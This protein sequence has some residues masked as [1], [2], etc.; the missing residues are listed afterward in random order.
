MKNWKSLMMLLIGLLILGGFS[1][2][3]LAST[4]QNTLVVAIRADIINLDPAYLEDAPTSA[5]GFQIYEH[6]IRRDFDGT[7]APGLA[8]D[9]EINDVADEY[10]LFLREGVTFHDGSPF[11]AEV[12]KYHFARIGDPATGS[13]EGEKVRQSIKEVVVVDEYTVRFELFDSNA[14]FIEDVLIG[15]AMYIASPTAIEKYGEDFSRNPSGT[16]PFKFVSW[17]PDQEVVLERNMDY[18]AGAPNIERVVFRPIPEATTQITELR[19]GTV[20]IITSIPTEYIEPLD[21]DP[22]IVVLNEPDFNLRYLVFNYAVEVLQDVNVRRG[23][24]HA[25]DVVEVVDV[26]LS[27]VADVAIGPLTNQSPYHDPDVLLYDYD[28]DL[29][30]EHFAKAGFTPGADGMLRNEQGETLRFTLTTPQGRYTND[31]ELNEA[32]HFQLR[33]IGVDV[34]LEIVEFAT[35]IDKLGQR[36]FDVG[37]IGMM[38]RTGEPASHLNIMY[39]SDGWANWGD[40]KNKEVD[41]LLSAG[42]RTGIEEERREIYNRIQNLIMEDV[43]VIPIMNELYIIAHRANIKDYTFTAARTHD[44]T[45]LYKE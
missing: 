37:Y 38:M 28:P 21:M 14:A 4:P 15:N 44:Y 39:R 11:N 32:I 45:T 22:D 29:A 34:Q 6:L 18:W 5:V 13:H 12:V 17:R 20:D 40:Y 26:F 2:S 33:E 36:D 16:G 42:L 24:H 25:I 41:E 35:L 30:L 8:L 19:V 10:T 9:W 27:G 23:L 7:F 3:L 43:P 1:T 31:R